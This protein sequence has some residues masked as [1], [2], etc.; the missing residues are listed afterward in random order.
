MFVIC[1]CKLSLTHFFNNVMFRKKSWSLCTRISR[2]IVTLK[3]YCLCFY[4]FT[5]HRYGDATIVL[6]WRVAK[7]RPMLGINSVWAEKG[8]Y[9]VTPAVTRGASNVL[10][11]SE[12]LPQFIK[13]VFRSY[14]NRTGSKW[15]NSWFNGNKKSQSKR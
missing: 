2:L 14:S 6:W 8:L 4:C 10:V 9:C 5:S 7:S 1:D 11:S 3:V 15:D 13:G 12:G